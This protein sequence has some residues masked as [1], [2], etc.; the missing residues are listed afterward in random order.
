MP[1]VLGDRFYQPVMD[2]GLAVFPLDGSDAYR[3]T[4]A[5]GMPD[6]RIQ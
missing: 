5:E 6:S 3:I 2:N 1:A 4:E